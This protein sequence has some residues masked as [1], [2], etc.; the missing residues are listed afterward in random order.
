[1]VMEI[2]AVI[3]VI[4]SAFTIW[5]FI[6]VRLKKQ[7]A[8]KGIQLKQFMSISQTTNN[9]D[10]QLSGYRIPNEDDL[11]KGDWSWVYDGA[12]LP[13]ITYGNFFGD[14]KLSEALILIGIENGDAQIVVR[15][16]GE[17]KFMKLMSPKNSPYNIEL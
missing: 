17:R 10:S 13:F 3:G 14:G 12:T 2:V 6:V 4:A 11:K 1:M 9:I 7:K 15:R 5:D 16:Y 8:F